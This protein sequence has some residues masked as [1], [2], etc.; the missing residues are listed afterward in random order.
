MSS[1]L[2]AS[3]LVA[4]GATA[5]RSGAVVGCGVRRHRGDHR[6]RTA[7]IPLRPARRPAAGERAPRGDDV[8]R[9]TATAAAAL[10]GQPSA[11]GPPRSRPGL[12][13]RARPADRTGRLRRRPRSHPQRRRA[14]R[15]WGA[16]PYHPWRQDGG[17]RLR[18]GSSGDAA[19]GRFGPLPPDGPAEQAH[20]PH[21]G[22]RRAPATS[23]RRCFGWR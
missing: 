23:T 9:S 11:D 1:N 15:R 16:P 10:A 19:A 6:T 3:T 14:D 12:P 7:P 5:H 17:R 18:Q 13:G 2:R 8:R 21:P 20:R 22:D 4:A